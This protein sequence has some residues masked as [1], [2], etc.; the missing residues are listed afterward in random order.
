M[1][2]IMALCFCIN[3]YAVSHGLSFDV[4]QQLCTLQTLGQWLDLTHKLM[5][6]DMSDGW[7]ELGVLGIGM[8]TLHRVCLSRLCAA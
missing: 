3:P 1:F 4:S 5:C 2:P 7:T 6:F 8:A